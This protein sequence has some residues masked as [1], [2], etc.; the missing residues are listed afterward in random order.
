MHTGKFNKKNTTLS[1]SMVTENRMSLLCLR[2]SFFDILVTPAL[3]LD[4][5]ISRIIKIEQTIMIANGINV[6]FTRS[7]QTIVFSKYKLEKPQVSDPLELLVFR[8]ENHN[9]TS[10]EV[11]VLV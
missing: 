3:N 10:S 11:N 6:E 2:K 5:N 8:L 4:R 1:E 9:T 7:T